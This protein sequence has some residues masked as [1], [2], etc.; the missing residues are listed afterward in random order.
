MTPIIVVVQG[1]LVQGVCTATGRLDVPVVVI[2]YDARDASLD[3]RERM[4]AD[5][6]NA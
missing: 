6:E 5:N 3:E 4:S 2:D 1:G